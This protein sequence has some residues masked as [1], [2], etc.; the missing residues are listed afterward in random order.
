VAA[1]NE[2]IQVFA[3]RKFHGDIHSACHDRDLL[4]QRQ[5]ANYLGR[6]SPGGQRNRF[7]LANES[8][9]RSPNSSLFISKFLDLSL[10]RTVIPERFVKQR[11]YGNR[12]AVRSP[13]PTLSLKGVQIPTN[14]YHRYMQLLAE[15]FD[16]HRAGLLQSGE[17]L[18]HPGSLLV[19]TFVVTR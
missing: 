18:V 9:G 3:L 6:S 12:T 5:P 7:P 19:G 14:R 8:G 16:R 4:I 13:E 2:D 10:K 17:N 15:F 11:C 1:G